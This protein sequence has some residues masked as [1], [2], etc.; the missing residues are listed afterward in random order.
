[1]SCA[2]SALGYKDASLSVSEDDDSAKD[3]LAKIEKEIL[4]KAFKES[5]VISQ[6]RTRLNAIG[7]ASELHSVEPVEKDIIEPG[8]FVNPLPQLKILKEIFLYSSSKAVLPN[9]LIEVEILEDLIVKKSKIHIRETVATHLLSKLIA[10]NLTEL[11]TIE[12]K[13]NCHP[14]IFTILNIRDLIKKASYYSHLIDRDTS[15][16]IAGE[17]I[18]FQKFVLEKSK[19]SIQIALIVLLKD[20]EWDLFTA[21]CADTCADRVLPIIK[22]EYQKISKDSDKHLKFLKEI[23][24]VGVIL[25]KRYCLLEFEKKL[26]KWIDD[27]D[28][29]KMEGGAGTDKI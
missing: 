23:E 13:I 8:F 29:A 15:R 18:P 19:T 6:R 9:L 28:S 21:F 10:L 5:R 14:K 27:Q 2:A 7:S 16:I 22:N 26:K 1:M 3:W 12:R 25:N 4:D 11:K 20:R 17:K 24:K